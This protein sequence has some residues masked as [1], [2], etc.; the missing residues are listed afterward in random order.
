MTGKRTA[1]LIT[2]Q[3]LHTSLMRFGIRIKHIQ[4]VLVNAV[5]K[6]LKNPLIYLTNTKC[7]L[8]THIHYFQAHKVSGRISP[9]QSQF[10]FPTGCAPAAGPCPVTALPAAAD[11]LWLHSL[12]GCSR[13]SMA[14]LNQALG[15]PLSP[16][17]C[18]RSSCTCVRLMDSQAP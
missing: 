17:R 11:S 1:T 16:A 10:P 9:V 3:G 4:T 8:H 14:L 12:L 6:P 5:F 13:S 2:D 15:P 7:F 18:S